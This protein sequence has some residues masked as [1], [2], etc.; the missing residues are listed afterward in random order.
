MKFNIFTSACFFLLSQIVFASALVKINNKANTV[1]VIA[2]M[3]YS[4]SALNDRIARETTN[5][6][7]RMWNEFPTSVVINNRSYKVVFKIDYV[8]AGL[9]PFKN[10]ESCAYNFIQILNKTNPNDRSFYNNIGSNKGTFFTSD[11]LGFST[12]T[13][14]E[15]GHG[16]GLDHNS[17]NQTAAEI[18]GIMF[19]RGT[20][21]KPEFQ[22]NPQAL[23]GEPGS[24]INPSF[25]K[26]RPI[27]IE[28][29]LFPSF[30]PRTLA[31]IGEGLPLPIGKNHH[32]RSLT[33][34]E[35]D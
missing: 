11:N 24:T 35:L 3:V 14:H 33:D 17:K 23:P 21:V 34:V 30:E 7:N 29:I 4:G 12:T 32:H 18:P 25:R 13:A 22:W 9:K 20:F 15:F 27:D 16:L 10:P 31:C 28:T 5:E 8:I 19:A 26:V 1:F 2:R 6:I